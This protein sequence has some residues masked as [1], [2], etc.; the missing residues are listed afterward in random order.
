MSE[1]EDKEW[2]YRNCKCRAEC[3]SQFVGQ[4]QRSK[5]DAD[6][7]QRRDQRI[8]PSGTPAQLMSECRDGEPF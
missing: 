3:L 7:A 6:T 1:L 8:L 5:S 4:M 2:H